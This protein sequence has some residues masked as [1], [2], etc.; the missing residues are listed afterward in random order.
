MR[1]WLS[2]ASAC[3]LMVAAPTSQQAPVGEWRVADGSAHVRIVDCSGVLWGIVSWEETPGQDV[4]NPDRTLRDRPTLGLPV[5]LHMKPSKEAGR[6]RGQVYNADNGRIYTATIEMRGP[7]TLRVEGCTLRIICGG[8]GWTRVKGEA[9]TLDVGAAPSPA[10]A[11]AAAICA[12]VGAGD[13]AGAHLP[14]LAD[15]APRR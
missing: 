13:G 14:P 12:R 8:E 15:R 5:L 6:W 7:D 3:L 10:T 9:D 2:T 1:Y 11:P 4:H